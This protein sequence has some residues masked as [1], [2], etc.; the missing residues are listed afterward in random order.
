MRAS[1][2]EHGVKKLRTARSAINV[3]PL[4]YVTLGDSEEIINNDFIQLEAEWQ[5][6]INY[7]SRKSNKFG[8]IFA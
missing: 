5:N 7:I 8:I 2:D 4:F 6:D 3:R 1:D